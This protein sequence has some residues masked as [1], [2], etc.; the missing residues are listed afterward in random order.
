MKYAKEHA[1]S[2][3]W[4]MA[5]AVIVFL[6]FVSGM[7]SGCAETMLGACSMVEGAGKMV[8]GMGK[9]GAAAVRNQYNRSD[10]EQYEFVQH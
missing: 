7:L 3:D 10:A 5:A 8:S 1:K 4:F 2:R 6:L 9:D